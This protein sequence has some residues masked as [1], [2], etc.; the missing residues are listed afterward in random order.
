MKDVSRE[1]ETPPS[2]PNVAT[3]GGETCRKGRSEPT[4]W[5]ERMLAALENGV[6]GGK[7]YSLSDKAFGAPSLLAAFRKVKANQGAAGVD[8]MTISR[9]ESNLDLEI[10][11]LSAALRDGTYRPQP[12]RRVWIPKPGSREK[13]GLGIPTVRD[14]VVQTA[15]H[16]ALEP[17]FEREFREG[18]YG[19]RPGR[20]CHK[21]LK[22]VWRRVKSSP[23]HVVDADLR[24]CFDTIP[25]EL[26][27][28]GLDSKVSD[29][30]LLGVVRAFLRQGVMEGGGA[31]RAVAAE[32]GTPQGSVVSP[33][34]A[35]IALHGLDLMAEER[36]FDLVRFADDFVVLCESRE[37]AEAALEAVSNWTTASGLTLHP[38]K[39]RIVNQG[40]GESFDFLG[41][42]FKGHRVYPRTK[43]QQKFREFVRA[44]TPRSSGASLAATV[45]ILNPKIRGWYNYFRH[46]W[47]TEFPSMDGFVRRRL[48][49]IL[50]KQHG[51]RRYAKGSDN[52]RWPNAYF[53]Q[54]GLFSMEQA[55]ARRSILS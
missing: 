16:A 52:L 27:M 53:D 24:K 28:R 1:G 19:F 11:R 38:V 21:A 50:G 39:T 33:L 3:Q 51:I 4:I 41:Y 49:S 5:T 6:Q 23:T 26:I 15:V 48:R 31:E 7:W 30:R 18:S 54:L 46:S 25:H 40:S 32:E 29:G 43:S 14:R 20:S 44:A 45:A 10:S 34:L 36:G 35:N 12:I 13:R 55:H 17:I 22:K 9:F 2:V 37:E 8:R 47:P 42:K